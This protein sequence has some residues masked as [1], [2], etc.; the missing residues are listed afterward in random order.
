MYCTA[1]LRPGHLI[2]LLQWVRLAG[3]VCHNDRRH[4]APRRIRSTRRSEG[5]FSGFGLAPM[6]GG[7]VWQTHPE[8]LLPAQAQ[9]GRTEDRRP[10]VQ[11]SQSRNGTA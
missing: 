2:E 6:Q 1:P 7:L 11:D 9:V 5:I 4:R 3:T 10:R 8:E